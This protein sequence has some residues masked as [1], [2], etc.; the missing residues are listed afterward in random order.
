MRDLRGVRA[1]EVDDRRQGARRGAVRRVALRRAVFG[2]GDAARHGVDARAH[3]RA[4][5]HDDVITSEQQ[6]ASGLR[7]RERGAQLRGANVHDVQQLAVQAD[8]VAPVGLDDVGLVHPGHLGVGGRV[9]QR[10]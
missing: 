1:A 8:Q 7:E 9:G 3:R 2:A 4:G 10:S 5:Q 6:L